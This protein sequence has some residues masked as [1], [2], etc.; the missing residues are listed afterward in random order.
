MRRILAGAL[1]LC[2]LILPVRG[3][4]TEKYVALTFDDGPS[5]R[6]TRKLLEGLEQRQ[7]KAT[8]ALCGY[9]IQQSPELAQAI[10][11][12]GHEIALH[13]Y[14]HSCMGHMK[15]EKVAAEIQETLLLL[16]EGCQ[17]AFL[18]PPGGVL[19]ETVYRTAKQSGFALLGWSIDPKDWATHNADAVESA[20]EKSVKDGDIIL[21]HDMSDSSVNA[22]LAIIDAL[23][24]E[25]YR[26][27]TV[28]ALAELRG[29]EI[30]SGTLY[31]RFRP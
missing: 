21:L 16:P 6:F 8:F 30:Q 22:A 15:A 20:V 27:V 1:C 29:V 19:S 26:F 13:G 23:A 28:S 18:R 5:G 14:S 9:R 4:E 2:L 31:S 7:V 17:P 3:E 10:F 11:D 25:G 12:G 24:E